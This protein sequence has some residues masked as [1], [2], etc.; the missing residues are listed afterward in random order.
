MLLINNTTIMETSLVTT[1]TKWSIDQAHSE[2][3]FKIRHLMISNVKG[4]FKTFDANIYT[5]LKDFSTAEIDLWIDPSSIITGDSKRD[6]HLKS[7]DFFD[8]QKH[9]QI[10][11]TSLTIGKPD[12]KGNHELWGELTMVGVTK[13]LKLN[14]QFGGIVT[15][16][17]KN[18]KAGF[19]VTGTIKRSDWGL[20]WNTAL[21]TGGFMVSDEV[22]ILCEIE[23][24]NSNP[25]DLTMELEPAA[26][27]K[28]M[29]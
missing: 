24:I 25:K 4:S 12:A 3:E 8:V 23:L 13:N 1:K 22:N 19:T 29:A 14:V 10:S 20:V 17:W 27:Q 5:T 16:P 18:E 6:E 28:T 15:D 9:K 7:A 11:F 2:I 26:E 21:E